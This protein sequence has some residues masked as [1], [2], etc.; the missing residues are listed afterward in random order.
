MYTAGE[1]GKVTDAY[2]NA[3]G[4]PYY[5]TVCYGARESVEKIT[6]E[7]GITHIGA[8]TCSSGRDSDYICPNLK[9]VEFPSTLE[10]IGG[11]SFYHADGKFQCTLPAG[12]KEVGEKAFCG[13]GMNGTLA[14]CEFTNIGTSAFHGVSGL[15]GKLTLSSDITSIGDFAFYGCSSLEE[16]EIKASVKLGSQVFYGTSGVQKVT[17]PADTTWLQSTEANT[18]EG[19]GAKEIVYTAG[20]SGKVTDAYSN[21]YG[22]PYYGT[23]C[24]GARE[25]VEKITFAEGITHIGAYTCYCGSGA[26]PNLTQ[27][28]FPDSLVS[29]GNCAFYNTNALSAVQFPEGITTLNSTSFY[30]LASGA[31]FYGYKGTRAESYASDKGCTFVALYDPEISGIAEGDELKRG[32]TYQLSAS[33]CTGIDTYTDEADW[34]IEGQ[35]YEGTTID[36]TGKLVIDPD[37]TAESI[38][39]TASVGEYSNSVDVSVKQET[40]Q[41]RF[42]GEIEKELEIRRGQKI[43][44]PVEEEEVGYQYTYTSVIDG[45]E[46]ILPDDNWERKVLSD[47]TIQVSRELK[48]FTVTFIP[49]EGHFNEEGMDSSTYG[50]GEKLTNMP[51]PVRDEY[52][53]TGWYTSEADTG[54]EVTEEDTCTADM[55]LYAHWIPHEHQW[56]EGTITTDPTCT[57]AGVMTYTCTCGETREEPIEAL[58]HDYQAEVTTEPGCTEEGVKTFTCS[59]CNDSYTE[60]IPATDHIWNE[61][62]TVD[63]EATC[64]EEGSESKHCSVCDIVQEGSQRVIEK[65]PHSYG[66]WSVT[67][68]AACTEAGSREKICTG[69]GDKVTEDIPATGHVYG[70][71]TSNGESGHTRIC[72]NDASHTESEPHSFGDWETA[73]EATYEQT[74]MKERVC[75]DCGYKEQEEIPKLE[76]SADQIA[77]ESAEAVI[78]SLPS[79]ISTSDEAAIQ[80]AR[81]AYNSLSEDQKKL[82]PTEVVNKLTQA[83]S[84]I[85]TLKEAAKQETGSTTPAAAPA[86]TPA[87]A[88]ATG[89]ATSGPA[90]GTAVNVAGQTVT[91]TS[92]ATV[93][94][95]KAANKKAVTVP[96]TMIINGKKYTVTGIA[97]KAFTGKKIKTVTVGKSITTISKNAFAK[98]KVTKLIIKTKNL[99]KKSVKGSLKGSKVKTVQVKVGNKKANKKFVKTYKK[100]FTKKNAGKKVTLK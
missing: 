78:N 34:R 62:Y 32:E 14:G 90:V 31:K 10:S 1:S 55:I 47:I 35:E 96:E 54:A 30:N 57:E 24:Y 39:I 6:F 46:E 53:F 38:T 97:A 98:S 33:T 2:F 13:S 4:Y 95:T 8:Y 7:E 86:T 21:A 29:I 12:L 69:C 59:R 81:A 79:T 66:E 99:S 76:K 58:G 84:K 44:R 45:E 41:V 56:D 71:W 43:S 74:G 73:K 42:T 70:E 63:K 16:I 89:T 23:V 93:I 68:E 25:S 17:L 49:G 18:F 40:Y 60:P 72:A 82:I 28:V 9:Q 22:Y 15:K 91:V 64:T 51:V 61:D 36:G 87:S 80:E 11:Y 65:L 92:Q 50:Y 5:G 75:T 52:D 88:P 77:A 48:T 37:E 26:Y 67:K 100:I 83:E 85:T 94:F 3:Y 27:I 19:C 20:E